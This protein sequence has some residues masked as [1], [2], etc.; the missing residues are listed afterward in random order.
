MVIGII[1]KKMV[2]INRID[3]LIVKIFFI[4]YFFM[5]LFVINDLVI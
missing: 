3:N 5:K 2:L 4:V 1:I